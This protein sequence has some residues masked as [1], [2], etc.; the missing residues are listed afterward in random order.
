MLDDNS[1]IYL[2][3]IDLKYLKGTH[4]VSEELKRNE[5]LYLYEGLVRSWPIK[6]FSNKLDKL[7]GDGAGDNQIISNVEID[8]TLGDFIGWSIDDKTPQIQMAMLK[9]DYDLWKHN[10]KQAQ[11]ITDLFTFISNAGYFIA[12][13]TI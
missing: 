7:F 3:Y 8:S 11:R 2:N 4:N 5:W 9:S 12:K 10:A 1:G 6:L 13:E